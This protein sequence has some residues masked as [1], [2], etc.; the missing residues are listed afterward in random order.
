MLQPESRTLLPVSSI[1]DSPLNIHTMARQSKSDR[2]KPIVKK[3]EVRKNPDPRIDEDFPGFPH[4]PSTERTI[5]PKTKTEK[6]IARV[7]KE[8]K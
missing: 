8:N 4:P 1:Y 6:K 3:E 2:N 7:G 5:K